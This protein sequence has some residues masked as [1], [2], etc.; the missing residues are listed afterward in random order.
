[1][2]LDPATGASRPYGVGFGKRVMCD[3]ALTD[4]AVWVMEDQTG[5]LLGYSRDKGEQVGEYTVANLR[6]IATRDNQ[7]LYLATKNAIHTISLADGTVTGLM[8]GFKELQAIAVDGS[9]ILHL[10]EGGSSQQMLRV[11][12]K[13]KRILARAGCKGGR[14]PTVIPYNPADFRNVKDIAI[15]A[16]GCVWVVEP[17]VA[18]RRVGRF[19]SDSTWISDNYGPTGYGLVGVDLDDPATV[20]FK[21]RSGRRTSFLAATGAGSTAT[22]CCM[23]WT[24]PSHRRRSPPAARPSTAA[25][26]SPLRWPRGSPS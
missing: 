17:A 15:D 19:A 1:M 24:A 14:T 11:D 25:E 7:S 13:A 18:P 16:K 20:W 12:A 9:G 3:L 10:A 5:I 22:A 23:A 26:P 6:G 2:K 8:E 21:M 4:T